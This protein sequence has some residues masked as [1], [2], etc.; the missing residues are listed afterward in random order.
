MA[1]L[2]LFLDSAPEPL[3]HEPKSRKELILLIEDLEYSDIESVYLKLSDTN[4]LTL[5]FKEDLGCYT[6]FLCLNDKLYFGK[7][8]IYTKKEIS[9]TLEMFYAEKYRYKSSRPFVL[10]SDLVDEELTHNPITYK[11]RHGKPAPVFEDIEKKK[12]QA[13][14]SYSPS[15]LNQNSKKKKSKSGAVGGGISLSI[16]LL[17]AS[18]ALRFFRT[19][20]STVPDFSTNQLSMLHVSYE[21]EIVSIT[22]HNTNNDYAKSIMYKN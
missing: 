20:T 17:I 18:I 19:D 13:A 6:E 10:C 8:E 22:N 1:T 15:S 11:K 12:R 3:V 4:Y 5:S 16:I 14:S 2:I 21:A 7:S 9:Y